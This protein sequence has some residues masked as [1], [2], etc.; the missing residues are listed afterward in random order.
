MRYVSKRTRRFRGFTLIEAALTTAIISFG[1]MGMLQ[2]LATGTVSN[3]NG[4]DMTMGLNLARNIR[5]LM[6]GLPNADPTTPTHWGAET[7]ETLATYDDLDDFNDKSFSPPIDARRQSL[8]NYSG[9]TQSVRVQ[10]VD[11]NL[12]TSVVPNGS[13]PALRVTVTIT[14]NGKYVCDLSWVQFDA[15]P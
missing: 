4:T 8:A 1:V 7:G 10:N 14:H 13:S 15:L 6:V 2:L 3:A 5:E 11:N 9:W 12:L